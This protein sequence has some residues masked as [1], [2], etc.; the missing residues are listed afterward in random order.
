MET[1]Q[2]LENTQEV[3][4]NHESDAAHAEVHV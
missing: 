2:I 1:T 4:A 3:I